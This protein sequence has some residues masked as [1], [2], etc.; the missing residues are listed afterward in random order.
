[1][2]EIIH[3][4]DLGSHLYKFFFYNCLRFLWRGVCATVSCVYQQLRWKEGHAH[5]CG[6]RI[7][8]HMYVIDCYALLGLGWFLWVIG[9]LKTVVLKFFLLT[10]KRRLL[11]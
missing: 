6:T 4:S 10:F 8:V 2:S 7:R 11:M 5:V 9:Q 1:M 3:G